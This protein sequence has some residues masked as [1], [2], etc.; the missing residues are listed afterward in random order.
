M[1]AHAHILSPRP[2]RPV[3]LASGQIGNPFAAHGPDESSILF[4]ALVDGSEA[5]PLVRVENVS[6]EKT[7][8]VAEAC[9]T[10]TPDQGSPFSSES[11]M[12]QVISVAILEFGIILHRSVL[13]RVIHI[14]SAQLTRLSF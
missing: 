11:A 3:A 10:G 4:S 9:P 8:V 2:S 5:P 7:G 6:V 12:A 13:L 1:R 14:N